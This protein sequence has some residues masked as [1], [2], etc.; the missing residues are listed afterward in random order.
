MI[1]LRKILLPTDFSTTAKT[2]QMY[3]CSLAQQYGC[4]LHI[5]HVIIDP[6]YVMPPMAGAYIPESYR[7]DM[8]TRSDDELSKLPD[9]KTAK[10][11]IYREGNA[12]WCSTS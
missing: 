1:N 5:I 9:D 6:A 11:F 12:R 4:E 3:A 7:E 10:G 8:K 2:A